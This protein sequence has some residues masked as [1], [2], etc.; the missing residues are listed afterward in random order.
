MSTFINLLEVVYPVGTIYQSWSSTSPATIFGGTWTQIESTFLY[1]NTSS[2]TTGGSSKHDHHWFLGWLE[3]YGTHPSFENG[4]S[5]VCFESNNK[6]YGSGD[7]KD[8]VVK[9]EKSSSKWNHT[10]A[11]ANPSLG[12]ATQP[13]S[14]MME[15]ATTDTSTLPPYVTCYCW[16]RTA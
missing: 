11:I 1:P 5:T 8:Y 14:A 2:G 12:S 16:R 9:R 10:N 7:R 13:A 6:V 3:W 4:D 15:C